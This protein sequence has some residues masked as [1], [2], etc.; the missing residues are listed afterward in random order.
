MA[1][2]K[3]YPIYLS[4]LILSIFL[5]SQLYA[6]VKIS[7]NLTEKFA[8]SKEEVL[9]VIVVLRTVKYK[10]DVL[11]LPNHFSNRMLK[12]HEMMEYHTAENTELMQ[13][14]ISGTSRERVEEITPLWS[15]NSIII[16]ASESYIHKVI[17]HNRNVQS[18]HLSRVFHLQDVLRNYEAYWDIEE[19]SGEQRAYTYGLE[20]IGIPK[21]E[22]AVPGLTGKGILVGIIDTGIDP[23]HPDLSGKIY[24]W[25]DFTASAKPFPYDD[26]DHGTHTAGTIAGGAAS[27]TRIGVAPEVTLAVA[28]VFDTSGYSSEA[29][30]LKAMEWMT[31]PDGNPNTDDAPL[32]VS[33]SWGGKTGTPA[34]EKPFREAVQKWVSLGIFP[35]FAAGN[36]G[37]N[38]QTVSTPGAYPQSFA[39]GATDE[40]D[41]VASFSS[42]G[43]ITI[44]T[45]TYA[46]PDVSAPGVRVYSSISGGG[47]AK[48]SGT[49]M[50]TPHAAG[51]VALLYQAKPELT[52][53]EIENLLVYTATDVDV[54]DYDYNTGWGRIN[55]AKAV[56]QLVD[57]Q[58]ELP[59]P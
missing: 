48:F 30:I 18:V 14:M 50:A 41:V 35:V 16:K 42:R 56:S 49:S 17:V 34:E 59:F 27:G 39:I 21:I 11:N 19:G 28:K 54:K 13:F 44:G 38:S 5:S 26:N 36:A 33:N 46:K 15:S 24:A 2:K 1:S 31:D 25:K 6:S 57:T 47:Y 22:Q 58:L 45:E 23:N 20:K 8:D 12:M 9:T 52:V 51:V 32:L 4:I 7:Q 3:S 53:D 37:P 55:A 40:S 43:P 29:I 10:S